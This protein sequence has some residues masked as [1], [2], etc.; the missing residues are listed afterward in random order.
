MALWSITDCE[1]PGGAVMATAQI[2]RPRW[3]GTSPDTMTE[4]QTMATNNAVV[5]VYNSHTE[6][7][8]AVK[9]LQRSGNSTDVRVS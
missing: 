3:R 7:E 2:L 8:A 5:G 6:G 1:N 4:R 9:E